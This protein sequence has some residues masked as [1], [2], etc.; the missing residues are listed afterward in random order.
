MSALAI[1]WE[2]RHAPS[3]PFRLGTR[4]RK[5]PQ[6]VSVSEAGV[7]RSGRAGAASLDTCKQLETSEFVFATKRPLRAKKPLAEPMTCREWRDSQATDW[8]DWEKA[9]WLHKQLLG[10]VQTI[11]QSWARRA[12]AENSAWLAEYKA[13]QQRREGETGPDAY[14]RVKAWLKDNKPHG[15]MAEW[16]KWER[17]YFAIGNCGTE[18]VGYQPKCCPE[19]T[20]GIAVPVGC[21]HRLCPKCAYH[22]SMRART[23]IKSQFDR[24]QHPVLFTVTVPNLTT[25]S[26]HDFKVFRE[27]WIRKWIAQRTATELHCTCGH[28]RDAHR[29]LKEGKKRRTLLGCHAEGC[30]CQQWQPVDGGRNL[31]WLL[32]GGIYSLEATHN[33]RAK[34]WHLHAHILGDMNRA[35]PTKFIEEG[36]KRKLNRVDF[37][38]EKVLAFTALKWRM[39]FDWL[40]ITSPCV[41]DCGCSREQHIDATGK[42]KKLGHCHKCG[43]HCAKFKPVHPWGTRPKN[44]PP[45]KSY[46]AIAKW[47]RHWE[48]YWANF[49]RWVKERRAHSTYELTYRVGKH[50][51]PRPDLTAAEF[52]EYER[53]T[54]WNAENTRVFHLTPV[55]DREGAAHEVLKY[56][57][58]VADFSDNATAVEEFSNAARGARM[59]QTFGTWY[60]FVLEVQ[61]D[62]QHMDD[63]SKRPSCACGRNHWEKVGVYRYGD[64]EMDDT[65]RWLL[66]E[67][68]L[69]H[70]IGGTVARPRIRGADP[71]D[72]D[73]HEYIDIEEWQRRH[74]HLES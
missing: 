63:W 14:Q 5:P 7:P 52:A 67:S 12:R 31:D 9:L 41:C 56:I 28:G 8:E 65:G 38:G 58:K 16:L 60:G 46:K 35:L 29:E 51:P 39:E 17:A 15:L 18:W 44:D 3:R 24:L 4:R 62:P 34:S 53:R 2:E 40:Q 55:I 22:R 21:N 73:K 36:G 61:F 1:Q 25:I 11:M 71:Q 49:E 27:Y 33:R 6:A 74:A 19:K 45:K 54:A 47:R 57:T 64:V 23:R 20:R 69:K 48:A 26:K 68:A 37:F 10:T 30:A 72:G 32:M 13:V 59:V 70:N 66:R 43:E 42:R 50:R